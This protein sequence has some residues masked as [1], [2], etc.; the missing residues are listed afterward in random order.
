VQERGS[1]TSQVILNTEKRKGHTKTVKV[2]GCLQQGTA[3]GEVFI[4]GKDGEDVG[5]QQFRI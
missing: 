2:T 4:V 5:S 3:P 1:T